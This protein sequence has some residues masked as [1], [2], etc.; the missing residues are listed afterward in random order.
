MPVIGVIGKTGA[1]RPAKFG[2][3]HAEHLAGRRVGC[4]NEAIGHREKNRIQR[5]FEQRAELFLAR[6]QHVFRLFACGDVGHDANEAGELA[7]CIKAGFAG[8]RQHQHAAV[9]AHKPDFAGVRVGGGRQFLEQS[10][11]THSVIRVDALGVFFAGI[12]GRFVAGAV[13]ERGA[14]GGIDQPVAGRLPFKAVRVA[15]AQGLLH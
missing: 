7:G 11:V 15:D 13:E 14:T 12:V 6:P 3:G 5:L 10:G 1:A 8:F 4:E 9:A 2:F